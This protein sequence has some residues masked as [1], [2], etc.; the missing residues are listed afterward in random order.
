MGRGHPEVAAVETARSANMTDK[1][2]LMWKT[3][4]EA[5]VRAGNADKALDAANEAKAR[6]VDTPDLT[7]TMGDVW[8]LRG[9]LAKA[10]S[11]YDAALALEPS[12]RGYLG[13]S[14][15]KAVSGDGKG[16]A[17]DI[18]LAQGKDPL[19]L[20]DYQRA[21]DVLDVA[22]E[23]IVDLLRRIPQGVRIE[24]GPDMVPSATTVQ[25]R[26]AAIVELMVMIRVP[27]RHKESHDGRDLAYKL[28]AQ[29]AV[30]ALQFA[31][32]KSQEADM[33]SALSLSEAVKLLPRV[34]EAY[35]ME[36][37]YGSKTSI[38]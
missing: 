37:T 32:T 12:S 2:G 14:L 25:Q 15:A 33:E 7:L 21:M 20:A 19:P 29:S 3:A 5:W 10:I 30:E 4:A 26:T 22:I 23:S 38:D 6:G 8:L 16:A 27:S 31:K 11:Q 36:R 18:E 1:P 35:R 13:R 34:R 9:E 17:E 24:N 28:L